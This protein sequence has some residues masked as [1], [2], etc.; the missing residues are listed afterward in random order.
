MFQQRQVF[1]SPAAKGDE[2]WLEFNTGRQVIPFLEFYRSAIRLQ[3]LKM[4]VE[5][6]DVERHLQV[7]SKSFISR[8]FSL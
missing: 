7:F 4:F 2:Q 6:I 1:M 5:D 3:I 8:Q